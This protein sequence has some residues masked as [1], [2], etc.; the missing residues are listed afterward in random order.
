MRIAVGSI[1][2]ETNTFSPI[3]TPLAA[4][5]QGRPA[6]L[7]GDDLLQRHRGAKTGVGGFLDVAAVGGWEVVGTVGAS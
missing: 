2:H 3:P 1:M 5:H 4:F 6:I 7:E